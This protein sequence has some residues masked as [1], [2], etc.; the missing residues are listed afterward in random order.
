MHPEDVATRI[1]AV[2][3][4]LRRLDFTHV[5]SACES[6]LAESQGG[7]SVH[8]ALA[9]A[10][11]SLGR[12]DDA[13]A[14]SLQA[15]SQEPDNT[16]YAVAAA[17]ICARLANWARVF[18]LLHPHASTLDDAGLQL[19]FFASVEAAQYGCVTALARD[20]ASC[21]QASAATLAE[22]GRAL[23]AAR[24][25]DDA[26]TALRLSLH[27]YPA[28]A[29][30]LDG[31]ALVLQES[32]RSA[33]A[34][35][36]WESCARAAPTSGRAQLRLAMASAEK[37]R[38][39]E[40]ADARTR[41][42]ALGLSAE[43]ASTA[44]YLSLFDPAV[45]AP[46]LLAASRRVFAIGS[47]SQ[48]S[49]RPRGRSD[50]VRVGYVSAEWSITPAHY[51]ISPFVRHHDRNNVSLVLYDTNKRQRVERPPYLA[52]EDVWTGVAQMDDAAFARRVKED[53][54][55]VLVDLSGHYPDHRLHA[56]AR[57][58]AQTQATYPNYP[59]TTGC[60]NIDYLFTDTWMS[61]AG[62]DGEYSESLYRLT[63]G[64]LAYSPP[65]V[66]GEVSSLPAAR[67]NVTTLALVQRL[68]KLNGAMWDMCADILRR[69]PHC[70]LLVQ[71]G[72][73]ELDDPTS[74]LS[75]FLSATLASRD[76]DPRRASFRGPLNFSERMS[77]MADIDLALDT[78]P[79]SGA[80]TTC[81][82]LWMGVPV[83]TL[84][85]R[86]HVGRVTAGILQRVGLPELVT[87]SS[88][89]YVSRA[90]ELAG[91]VT[92][93]ADMRHTLRARFIDSGLT[94]GERLAA[95]LE[96]AYGSWAS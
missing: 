9:L 67:N 59:A 32:G 27:D 49:R 3:D 42:V 2:H 34:L 31:L 80:T 55:D 24:C 48:V 87:Y 82:C 30:A 26:E 22:A 39:K 76:V 14:Q 21:P 75:R 96:H 57:R 5:Q 16:Q 13:H 79:Y 12:L 63:P 36:L 56:F 38:A 62:S 83:L 73:P 20:T 72:E 88:E 25:L 35:A 17:S 85:G 94:D 68:S 29:R 19:Y 64:C 66:A 6:L 69:M 11:F 92:H 18:A 4:A 52:H 33:E 84:A 54:I 40:S 58:M 37:G 53:R 10:Y 90:C 65:L 93:L 1:A 86:T 50:R 43:D 7:A 89:Q 46:D 23:F 28:G 51:F 61:P 70:R 41:A 60:P 47:T 77:L 45:S 8:H 44:L 95:C 78:T 74:A 15:V 81:E 91:D 71:C